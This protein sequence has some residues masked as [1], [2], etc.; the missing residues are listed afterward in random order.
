[1]TNTQNT[2]SGSRL[3]IAC[4]LIGLAG[5][6]MV[7]LANLIGIIVRDGY[8]PIAQTISDLAIGDYAWIQDYGLD[9]YAV[10]LLAC[11]VGLYRWRA[12]G[13]WWEGTAILLLL[14]AFDI[15]LIAE[16][17]QY[18]G[19]PGRGA[20]I[21]LQLVY[22][23]GLLFTLIPLSFALGARTLSKR[24]FRFS[25]GITI[26]WLVGGPVFFFVPDGW[27]G[28]FERLVGLL[29]FAWTAAISWLLIQEGQGNAPIGVQRQ[30]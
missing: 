19:R 7:V 4:G 28:G 3:L 22:I 15:V 2:C 29:M 18:A 24:W 17:N 16:H 12:G 6:A 27:D 5:S 23:L 30:E 10:A 1:M 11:A 20:A 13:K 25:L 9:A 21:H 14:L 8:N 26:A